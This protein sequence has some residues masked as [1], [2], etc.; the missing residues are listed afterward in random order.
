MN[1]RLWLALMLMLTLGNTPAWAKDPFRTGSQ[2][3]AM[4]GEMYG[5]FREVFCFGRYTGTRPRLEAIIQATPDEPLAYAML[6]ALA[7]QEGNLEEYAQLARQTREVGSRIKGSDPVRGNLYEGMGMGMEAAYG[8]VKEGVVI[9]LPKALPLLNQ[10]FASLRAAQAADAN[11]PEVNLFI[12]Y[13]DL[14]LTNRDKALSQFQKAAPSYMALRGQSLTYRD[15]GNFA[16]AL[17]SAE[18]ALQTGCDN[19]ELHYLK[20]QALVGLK[21][22]ADAVLAF[23][24][25][26]ELGSQLPQELRRQIQRERDGAA[27]RTKGTS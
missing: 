5:A 24:R 22:D 19:P 2:A 13:I 18:Q 14:L 16:M 26:L 17:T 1:R 7:F 3:R 27:A 10:M 15:M 21:R 23:D 25:A 6:A 4:S 20:A 12:A 8:V 11:D 9:G